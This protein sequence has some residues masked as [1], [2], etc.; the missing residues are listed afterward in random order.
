MG[1]SQGF[2]VRSGELECD[3][4]TVRRQ[5]DIWVEL[6][7]AARAGAVAADLD[8]YLQCPSEPAFETI[9]ACPTCC[10]GGV[11][12]ACTSIANAFTNKRI[13]MNMVNTGGRKKGVGGTRENGPQ[14]RIPWLWL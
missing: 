9:K 7:D 10:G 11:G 2:D 12:S 4:C 13:G 14:N 5:D 3:D 6:R 8:D 1:K